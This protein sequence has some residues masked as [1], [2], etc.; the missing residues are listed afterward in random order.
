MTNERL[1]M[2]IGRLERA[3]SRAERNGHKLQSTIENP[4]P[5]SKQSNSA[6]D[7]AVNSAYQK[8]EQK[9][10]LL[11]KQASEALVAIDSLISG[12]AFDSANSKAD[13]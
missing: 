9:H 2:A 7:Q 11:K 3:L 1:I 13:L 5:L 6:A 10:L 12:S 4:P 8:L